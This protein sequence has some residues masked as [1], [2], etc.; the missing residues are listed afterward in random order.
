MASHNWV[1]A[2]APHLS[3]YSVHLYPKPEW[4]S[5]ALIA[6]N[7]RHA[8]SLLPNDSK[9]AFLEEFAPLTLSPAVSMREFL[10]VV[11][12]TAPSRVKGFT[13]FLCG[14]PGAIN[15][16]WILEPSWGNDWANLVAEFAS[17]RRTGDYA[18]AFSP[19]TSM[20]TS[21]AGYVDCD[22]AASADCKPCSPGKVCVENAYKSQAQCLD[23]KKEENHEDCVDA[24][25]LPPDPGPDCPPG[26]TCQSCS[27]GKVCVG[28]ACLD[29]NAQQNYPACKAAGC[30]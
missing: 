17:S 19:A 20:V 27:P 24:G 13:T 22:G 15:C 12:D 9:P 7:Y 23:C 29:C 14:M 3:Y 6:E 16:S 10:T 26:K 8:W 2:W 28:G 4:N 25:C 5:T 21:T 11:N 30:G 18:G 1:D